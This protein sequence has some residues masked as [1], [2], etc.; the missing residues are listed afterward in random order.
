[1][2]VECGAGAMSGIPVDDAFFD[3][4]LLDEFLAIFEDDP[5]L[6]TEEEVIY[7]WTPIFKKALRKKGIVAPRSAW[8]KYIDGDSMPG[9]H[10]DSDTWVLGTGLLVHPW[11]MQ[12]A[13]HPSWK[14]VAQV[15][16]WAW[17]G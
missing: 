6:V 11:E 2:S 4:E 13:Y 7:K 12:R 17:I 14:K 8:L 10:P 16:D 9:R 5:S 1:M 15:F 3:Q